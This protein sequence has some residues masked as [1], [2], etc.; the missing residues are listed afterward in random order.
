MFGDDGAATIAGLII[1]TDQTTL[2]IMC[3][4]QK[5]Y[6]VYVTLGNIS[7]DIRRKS[8]K[9]AT[10]LLGYLPV[11]NF[12]DI[13]DDEKRRQLKA[14][15]IHRAMEELLKPLRDASVKG[16]VMWC[17]DGRLRHIYPIVAAYI[18]DWPEQNLMACTSQG[19]CPICST[20]RPGRGDGDKD[21]PAPLRDRGE[22]LAALN[23]YFEHNDPGEL[24]ELSLKPIW[25]WWGDIPHINMS[26]CLTPD[27]LHQL[28]QGI[29]KTHLIRW[30]QF[31][32][33]VEKLDEQFVLMTAP[34]GMKHFSKGISHVQ[35]WTSRESKEMVKQ[36]LP[37][38][39]GELSPEV[40]E[41]VRTIV[42]FIFRAHTSVM[43]ER[44]ISELEKSLDTLHCL[45]GIM[46]SRGF[47]ESEARFDKI[48]KLHMLG[49]YAHAIRELGTPDG[50]NAEAPE[51]LHIE[52][53]KEPWR[54][55]NKVRPLPQMAKYVQRL[56]AMRIQQAKI[57]E[58]YGL[59]P[60]LSDDGD[61]SGDNDDLWH[62]VGL[63]DE[64][65][66][67]VNQSVTMDDYP[68]PR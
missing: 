15:L 4:G 65:E 61:N 3:G 31:L 68:S 21:N 44:D 48:P 32:L 63:D 45:K 30:L 2:S 60:L 20:K 62:E 64:G 54:A 10:V 50:Y 23:A 28:Y 41:L 38:V 9:H 7:K 6:P 35:Q 18:A 33:G 37:M 12:E 22:T 16:K 14:K 34:E 52:F 43:S 25:P 49:H 29:F 67:V 42:D 40:T 17:A 47:F 59:G 8:S 56:E 39:A 46:V 24:K 5:A 11:D 57:N 55:S 1:A 19:S 58:Y 53:A 13:I 26:S 27:L 51:H 66:G 36:I